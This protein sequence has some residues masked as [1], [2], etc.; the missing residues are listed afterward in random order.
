MPSRNTVRTDLA[1]SHYHV[2]ARGASKLPIFLEEVDFVYFLRLLERYLG[3]KRSISKAGNAYPNFH[4]VVVLESFCLMNNHF[5]LLV[6]QKSV[7]ELTQLMKSI[8]G[9]YTRYINLKYKR[10]GA[11]FESRYKAALITTDEYYVHVS[12]YIHLNPRRWKRYK[13]SSVRYYEKSAEPDWLN[14]TMVLS[15]FSDRSAYVTFMSD[16]QDYRDTVALIK[17]D[18]ADS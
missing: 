17:H 16:Y 8:M 11:L 5:H 2:Y 4:D 7:G 13:Y 18:L 10:S 14:T 6:Y 15:N 1:D 12:R 9:S 3:K